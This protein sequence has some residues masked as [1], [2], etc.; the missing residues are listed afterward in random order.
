MAFLVVGA[1]TVTVKPGGARLNTHEVGDRHRAFDGTYRSTVVDTLRSWSVTT[2]PMA[3]A[4]ANTLYTILTGTTQPTSCSGDLLGA[5]TNC[6]THLRDW[7]S[8]V[9][10]STH[11]IVAQFTL[12][13]SS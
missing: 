6:Y 5:A 9:A 2:T 12:E 8:V 13:E 4:T 3:R 1:A 11:R 10:D 7:S